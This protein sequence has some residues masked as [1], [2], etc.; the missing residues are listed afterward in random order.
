ML[1]EISFIVAIFLL[2]GCAPAI[3]TNKSSLVSLDKQNNCFAFPL[4]E[5]LLKENFNTQKLYDLTAKV[6]NEHGFDVKFGY[7]D[8]CRNFIYTNW[9]VSASEYQ[10]TQRGTTF[11]NNYGS[12]YANPYSN[13]INANTQSYSYTTPD[14]TY[15]SV[16]YY[17]TYFLSVSVFSGDGLIDVWEGSQSGKTYGDSQS[18]AEQIKDDDYD[19]VKKMVETMLFENGFINKK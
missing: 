12:A 11:T 13:S 4:K 9:I 14:Y 8:N 5:N 6:L 18:E 1:K 17:G 19:S 3:V 2:C 10:V 15:T 7:S 16:D